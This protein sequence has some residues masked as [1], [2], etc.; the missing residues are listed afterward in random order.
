M[1]A[2]PADLLDSWLQRQLSGDA[3]AWLR[4]ALSQLAIDSSDRAFYKLFGFVPRKVGKNDVLL[5]PAD[6]QQA[7]AARSGWDP[8]LWSVDQAARVLLLLRSQSDP[9]KVFA[10]AEQLFVTA[11]VGELVALY[12]GLPIYPQPQLY[13]KRAAEGIRT[14]IRPVFEAVAHFSPF[15]REQFD[16][17]AWNQMVLKAL[18]IGTPL[19]PIQG[20]DERANPTLATMLVNYA[21]ER[22]AAHRTVSP[23]LWRCVGPFADEAVLS[24]LQRVL[25]SED[26]REHQA[27]ALAIA[28]CPHPWAKEIM[29]VENKLGR[30]ADVSHMNW[31]QIGRGV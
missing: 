11:D 6:L 22:W 14:N 1:P 10:R 2:A 30:D 17:L 9:Q 13:V 8:H 31:E 27:A 16:D 21:H 12:R 20:L 7:G 19:W 5:A 29:A 18:F 3:S 4:E 28:A 15:P 26:Q 25:E 24:D 23:E